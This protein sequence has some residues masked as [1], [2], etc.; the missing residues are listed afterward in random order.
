MDQ[1]KQ[2]AEKIKQEVRWWA[3]AAWSLPFIALGV[4][5]FLE[6]FGFENLY[7]Q[8]MVVGAGIF[9]SIAVFWWWWAIYKIASIADL[10]SSAAD[11][12]K[13]LQT[14]LNKFKKNLKE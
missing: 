10:M 7:H 8:A 6:A 9:L 14:E 5:F 12:F 3:Y 1:Y 4:L 11:K 2:K 13:Q